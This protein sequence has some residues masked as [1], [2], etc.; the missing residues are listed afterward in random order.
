MAAQKYVRMKNRDG[1]VI[2]WHRELHIVPD[3]M[4]VFESDVTPPDNIPDLLEWK[5]GLVDMKARE[6]SARRKAEKV[7]A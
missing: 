6:V 3:T 7:E 2:D 5:V 1:R 4:E